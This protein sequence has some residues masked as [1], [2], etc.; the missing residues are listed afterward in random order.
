M[1]ME[2]SSLFRSGITGRPTTPADTLLRRTLLD[3]LAGEAS[4]LDI[5]PKAVHP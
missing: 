2:G 5:T 4:P 3:L 1:L